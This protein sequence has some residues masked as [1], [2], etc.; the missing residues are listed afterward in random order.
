LNL[1]SNQQLNTVVSRA[2]NQLSS[3]GQPP[4]SIGQQQAAHQ[5]LNQPSAFVQQLTASVM[6]QT[7]NQWPSVSQ[8]QPPSSCIG[9]NQTSFFGFP[10]KQLA[11]QLINQSAASVQQVLPVIGTSRR[12]HERQRLERRQR[13]KKRSR[14]R[15]QKLRQRTV[16]FLPSQI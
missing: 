1:N 7:S 13:R 2:P 3:V 11:N 5:L 10:Q 6:Q 15:R 14:Q 16:K 8:H 4:S 9:Q 12:K